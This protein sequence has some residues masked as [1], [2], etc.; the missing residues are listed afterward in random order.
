M[1]M[2]VIFGYEFDGIGPVSLLIS[3]LIMI[4]LS[5]FFYV[6]I[7]ILEIYIIFIHYFYCHI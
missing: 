4:L 5:C 7:D 3:S 2:P 1:M 6:L